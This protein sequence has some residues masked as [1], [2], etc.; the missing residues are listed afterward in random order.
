MVPGWDNPGVGFTLNSGLKWWSC[1]QALFFMGA[2]EELLYVAE[3][4]S[5][6]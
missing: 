3:L 2:G 5:D 1:S 6:S 4:E